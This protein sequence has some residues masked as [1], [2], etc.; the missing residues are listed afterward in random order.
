MLQD[1]RKKIINSKIFLEPFPY[2]FVKNFL[3]KNDITEINR[4]LPSFKEIEGADILYQSTSKTKKTL[5]PNSSIYKDLV[6]KDSFKKIN[7]LFKKLQ[8]IIIKKFSLEIAKHVKKQHQ[9]KKLNYHSSFSIMKN[10]YE[11]SAHLDRRDHLI[12]MILYTFS[13]HEK[14]GEIC[15]NK[16][17]KKEKVYD[18]FPSKKDLRVYKKHKVYSNSCIIILNVP[19]AYHSVLKYNGKSDRK[20]FYMV[21][22]FPVKKSGSKIKNRIKGFNQNEF[23]N[24]KVKVKSQKRKKVFLTE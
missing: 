18:I 2:L 3:N 1:V 22:D 4:E 10:G 15:M 16:T 20:Y 17:K 23:W 8:P 21:Y 11:K 13:Q 14:G 6:K 7:H 12:H 24:Y 19:W 9:N 5:L